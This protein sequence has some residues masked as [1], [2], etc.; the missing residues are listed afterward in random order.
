MTE[1]NDVTIE[2]DEIKP[3]EGSSTIYL[4][5]SGYGSGQHT[6]VVL[7]ARKKKTLQKWV[8]ERKFV[9]T[10]D[11]DCPGQVYAFGLECLRYVKGDFDRWQA[12]CISSTYWDV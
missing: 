8:A 2:V 9:R 12:I 1:V 7:T 3:L 10:H 6:L 4:D 5:E 11:G